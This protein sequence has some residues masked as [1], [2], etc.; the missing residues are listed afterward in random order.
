MSQRLLTPEEEK[1]LQHEISLY[2]DA[3]QRKRD[4]MDKLMLETSNIKPGDFLFARVTTG[5]VFASTFSVLGVVYRLE[6]PWAERQLFLMDNSV[7]CHY[8]YLAPNLRSAK[9]QLLDVKE[10]GKSNA[11]AMACSTEDR[12]HPQIFSRQE[13]VDAFDEEYVVSLEQKFLADNH[14]AQPT[15]DKF[16]VKETA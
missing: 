3:T 14:W 16:K 10:E 11:E 13:V 1:Q 5:S 9:L 4:F 2:I 15:I 8:L 12:N 7:K 6:R